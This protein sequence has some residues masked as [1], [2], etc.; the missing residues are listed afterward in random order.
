VFLVP[1]LMWGLALEIGQVL[2]MHCVGILIQIQMGASVVWLQIV[3][4]ACKFQVF[5]WD[6]AISFIVMY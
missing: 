1:N 2:D 3:I 4:N 5:H 6:F